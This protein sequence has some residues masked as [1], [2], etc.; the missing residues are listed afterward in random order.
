[1]AL[2]LESAHAPVA[3]SVVSGMSMTEATLGLI[4]MAQEFDSLTVQTFSEDFMLHEEAKEEGK[5]DKFKAKSKEFVSKTAFKLKQ[6]MQKIGDFIIHFWN[7]FKRKCAGLAV[8]VA[9]FRKKMAVPKRAEAGL[10]A[11]MEIANEGMSA[12]RSVMSKVG[13]E[14]FNDAVASVGKLIEN[15][16]KKFESV[17]KAG[18]GTTEVPLGPVASKAL[19][20]A[21]KASELCQDIGKQLKRHADSLKAD[22]EAEVAHARKVAG[23]MHHLQAKAQALLTPLAP[24]VL[25][26]IS[27]AKAQAEAAGVDTSKFDQAHAAVKGMAGDHGEE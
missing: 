14:G 26:F 25:H 23:D 12:V 22:N 2:F 15:A 20:T 18:E 6:W 24:K 19:Q 5:M 27:M 3:D 17:E 16:G 8:R 4:E 7:A 11:I 1:M 9:L 13:T 21:M 10:H